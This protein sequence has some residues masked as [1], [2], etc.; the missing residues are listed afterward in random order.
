VPQWGMG[1]NQYP[2]FKVIEKTDIQ[3]RKLIK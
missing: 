3:S 1:Y 2:V